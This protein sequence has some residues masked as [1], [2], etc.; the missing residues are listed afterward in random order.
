MWTPSSASVE[1]ARPA[2]A[3][4]RT[5]RAAARE[6]AQLPAVVRAQVLEHV[7]VP[8]AAAHAEVAGVAAVPTVEKVVDLDD[9]LAE[10]EAAGP[11][12]GAFGAALD[13]DAHGAGLS[14][15]SRGVKTVS[16]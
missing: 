11:L 4:A 9:L 16:P 7:E 14:P 2:R 8:V 10:D 5:A 15:V 3:E 6:R 1:H 12:A 13:L